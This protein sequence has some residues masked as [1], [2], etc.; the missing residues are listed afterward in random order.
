MR[1]IFLLLIATL[2]SCQTD[3]V[4][5]VSQAITAESSVSYDTLDL[6]AYATLPSMINE[7]SGLLLYN[8]KILTHNDS[9]DEPII[10]QVDRQTGAFLGK[11]MINGVKNIDWEE[12]NQ[13]EEFIYIGDFGN[14][15]G[16]RK[17]L[18]IF[19]VN[20]KNLFQQK[21]EAET[22]AFLYP[23]QRRFNTGAYRH[24]F[25]CESFVTFGDSLYLFSKNHVN[26]QTKSY[27][28]PK[29]SGTY[30]AVL[31]DS[32]DTGG[33]ITSSALNDDN[34]LLCMLGYNYENRTNYPFIWLFWNFEGTDFFGGQ[35]RKIILDME[36]QTEGITFYKDHQFIFSC[37]SERKGK[38]ELFLFDAGA[39]LE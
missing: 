14:N 11:A 37:E 38:G 10:Y 17:D 28:L 34:T 20:K 2:I 29:T 4:P 35:Q 5:S 18:A 32:F 1:F 3:S 31:R 23:D 21:I 8:D 24:N 13:D 39:Y 27:T 25:D 12:I 19:K 7:S 33:L 36:K 15:R 30:T 16:N 6:K 22:I 26:R 9:G